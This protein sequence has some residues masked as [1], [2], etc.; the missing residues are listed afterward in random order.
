MKGLPVDL[1]EKCRGR[2]KEKWRPLKRV[3]VLVGGAWPGIAD[4][5]IERNIAEDEAERDSGLKARP[6]GMVLL[7]DLRKIW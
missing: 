3:A 4:R 1:P 5:L 6:P 7:T 2:S